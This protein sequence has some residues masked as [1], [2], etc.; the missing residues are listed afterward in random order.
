MKSKLFLCA[1]MILA[2]AL[3]V[4]CSNADSSSTGVNSQSEAETTLRDF[5]ASLNSGDYAKAQA[6]YGGSYELLQDMNPLVDPNDAVTLFNNGCTMNG[7]QCLRVMNVMA[8]AQNSDGEF[9]FLVTFLNANG[10]QFVQ[11]PCCGASETDSPSKSEFEYTVMQNS[12]GQF[13]VMDLP[14]YVP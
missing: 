14:P 5:F 9:V 6:L 10:T 7:F 2:I 4:A 8:G 11:G 12:Q 1:V 13:V 3:S